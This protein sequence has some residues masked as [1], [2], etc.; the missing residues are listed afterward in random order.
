[1]PGAR[2]GLIV[3]KRL[4]R[5]ATERNRMKRALREEFRQ[6]VSGMP[7]LDVVVRVVRV[8]AGHELRADLATLMDRL[9]RKAAR[10]AGGNRVG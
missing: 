10:C 8:A 6:R 3:P 9:T 2:L 1:M 7:A 5:R 4:A